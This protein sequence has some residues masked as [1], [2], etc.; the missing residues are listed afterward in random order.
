M[1]RAAPTFEEAAKD[2]R[3]RRGSEF[4]SERNSISPTHA[5]TPTRDATESPAQPKLRSSHALCERL[6]H[7]GSPGGPDTVG[8]L[9]PN[10]VPLDAFL[11]KQRSYRTQLSPPPRHR[12]PGA[13]NT[14]LQVCR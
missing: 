6:T 10:G 4:V 8:R 3:G 12:P 1:T 7:E 5:M 9:A 13:D 14:P 2:E 11:N